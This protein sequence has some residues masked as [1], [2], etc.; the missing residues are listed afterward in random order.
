MSVFHHVS[1]PSIYIFH[2]IIYLISW[3]R[4]WLIYRGL[5]GVRIIHKQMCHLC[6]RRKYRDMFIIVFFEV[7]DL[8]QL[9]VSVCFFPSQLLSSIV[10][11]LIV[12][13]TEVISVRVPEPIWTKSKK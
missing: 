2:I 1:P 7:S 3:V 6:R 13:A 9:C 8:I 12:S 11:I 10:P 4:E 5:E